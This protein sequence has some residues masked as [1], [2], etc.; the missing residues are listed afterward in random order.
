MKIK[1]LND[2]LLVAR[3]EPKDTV[4]GGIVIPDSA[5]E[6]K[7]FSSQNTAELKSNTMIKNIFSFVKMMYSQLLNSKLLT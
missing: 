2:H 3:L 5:K 4:K 1:P 6:K 7:Q